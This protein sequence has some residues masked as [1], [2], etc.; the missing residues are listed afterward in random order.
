MFSEDVLGSKEMDA[1]AHP[2][3]KSPKPDRPTPASSLHVWH[4][5]GSLRH[6]HHTNKR[7][8]LTLLHAAFL[9]KMPEV[10]YAYMYELRL[11][12]FILLLPLHKLKVKCW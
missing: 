11:V 2:H 12:T 6:A 9:K 1:P 10:G 4:M 7:V 8:T 5:D 3:P